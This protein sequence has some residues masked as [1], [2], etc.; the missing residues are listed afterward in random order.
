MRVIGIQSPNLELVDLVLPGGPDTRPAMDE[1]ESVLRFLV[2]I[3]KVY[4]GEVV[5]KRGAV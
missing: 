1:D 4:C 5:L 2:H 3:Y